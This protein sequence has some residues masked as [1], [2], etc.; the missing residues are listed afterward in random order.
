M[1][2]NI[3][4]KVKKFGFDYDF[5][6]L[7]ESTL[8]N[9]YQCV[10]INNILSIFLPVITGAPQGSVIGPLL[11]T[12][13]INGLP[14][15]F[16]DSRS[17]LFTDHLKLSFSS[18]NFENDLARPSAWNIA[19]GMLIN[20]KK[21]K[22]WIF[23]GEVNVFIGQDSVENVSSHKDLGNAFSTNLKWEVRIASKLNS[24][25]ETCYYLKH[26][27]PGNTP[28]KVKFSLYDSS[29]LSILLYGCQIFSAFVKMLRK[30]EWFQKR[31]INWIFGKKLSYEDCLKENNVFTISYMIECKNIC[32]F[33]DLIN[34]N[35]DLGTLV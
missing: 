27:V 14:S 34:Y 7:I 1:P 19:N 22:C 16:L 24:A 23:K 2:F 15:V 26:T 33:I 5:I 31:C 12:I 10:S 32:F 18:L 9:R 17:W 28:S 6:N 25:S 20:A 29:V 13:F 30:M 11:F 21:S 35:F 4:L 8:Q 3:L